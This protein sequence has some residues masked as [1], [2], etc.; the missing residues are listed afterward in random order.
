MSKNKNIIIL[1]IL[2]G[3]I[4][5]GII[6]YSYYKRNNNDTNSKT[7]NNSINLKTDDSDLKVDW[8][9][10]DEKEI[11]DSYTI[12]EGG[13]YTLTGSING[14]VTINTEEDVKLILDGVTIKSN[15]GPAIYVENA[16]NVVIYLNDNT[17][18][19]LEDSSNYNGLD[20]DISAVIFS[21][22]DLVIDGT[23]TL[24][25][26][27]NYQDGI[28]SKDD[29]KIINGIYNITSKDDGIRGK[30]SVYIIDGEFTI[31]AGGDGIK[32]SNDTDT[33]KGFV[34]I[35]GGK[36]N[37]VA[38]SDGI[39]AITKLVINN[40]N[41][42]IDSSEGLE[43]TYIVIN[44]G[45]INIGASDDGV[46]ASNK[47]NFMTPTIE[48]NGGNINVTM[49]AGDTDGFD[50]NGNIY[51]NGGVVKVT[52]QSTF[53]YDG[54]GKI[55]GGEVYSNGEKINEL[56]NQIMGGGPQ[57]GNMPGG[58]NQPGGY[59]GRRR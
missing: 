50:A 38:K 4:V 44:G 30:D 27:A 55:N 42:D 37:I 47:S 17:T 49:G 20:E 56:P 25:V 52:G 26:N 1:F 58:G 35:E 53:D 43:A 57:G 34:L 23:G 8:D 7:N 59:Q 12:T 46:N 3:I 32:S 36:F 21:K 31:N 16:N 5:S 41:I 40:G 48:V 33:E 39:Q 24:I 10:L 22:D 9:G 54:E 6:G 19:T 13:S 51:I 15:N 29:L 18:N 14:T 28:V 45:I 11:D 2:M